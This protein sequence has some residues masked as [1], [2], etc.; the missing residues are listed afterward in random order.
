MNESGQF[1][2]SKEWSVASN[3]VFRVFFVL[4][5]FEIQY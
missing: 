3:K 4:Q 2:K 1:I 5:K